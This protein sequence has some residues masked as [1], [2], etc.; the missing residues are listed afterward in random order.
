MRLRTA[1]GVRSTATLVLA[2]TLLCALALP[3]YPGARATGLSSPTRSARASRVASL[4]RSTDGGRIAFASDREIFLINSDGSGLTQLTYSDANV[5]NYQP[6]LSPDGT[7][8]A[9]ATVQGSQAGIGI[10]DV[11]GAGLRMLTANNM[12]RDSEPAWSPDGSK[13]AFV[14]G[15]DPT[16]EGVANFSECGPARIYVTDVDGVFT[17]LVNLTPDRTATDP[18][19]SPDGTRIAFA[20]NKEGNY[21]IYSMAIDGTDVQQL[22]QTDE[23][24]AEPAWSPDGKTI[25][26]ASGYLRADVTCGFIHTGRG[27]D[28]I[29]THPDIYLMANDG[30]D[31][32]RLTETEKNI[33]PTWSPDGGSLAFVNFNDDVFEICV[34]N[35][36]HKTPFCITSDSNFKSSP[37]WSRADPRLPTDTK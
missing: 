15:F 37:S 16:S 3:G 23:Q 12:S 28:P 24:E 1:L 8:V 27:G 19:W 10:I 26:Y 20:S 33:E 5:Y 34:L 22:T 25:A 14:R 32:T 11:N 2:A 30:T 36:F 4:P 13:I 17:N 6:A 18:A 21:D 35:E 31:Q 29:L 9:F 7:R